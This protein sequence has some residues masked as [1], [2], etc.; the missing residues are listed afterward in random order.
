MLSPRSG[1]SEVAIVD[2]M[3][4]E[5]SFEPSKN[6]SRAENAA[7]SDN[8]Q[9]SF[10]VD[11]EIEKEARTVVSSTEDE[12][13]DSS[14]FV[15]SKEDSTREFLEEMFVEQ[16]MEEARNEVDLQSLINDLP[17]DECYDP[18]ESANF[19]ENQ[20][21][22]LG[23]SVNNGSSNTVGDDEIEEEDSVTV[24]RPTKDLCEE[25]TALETVVNDVH[26][27]IT[28]D[29]FGFMNEEKQT[30]S[31][32][33]NSSGVC[34]KNESTDEADLS[35]DQNS[36]VQSFQDEKSDVPVA[37]GS[38]GTETQGSDDVIKRLFSGEQSVL[39]F[40]DTPQKTTE[41]S[42]LSN[43]TFV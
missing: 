14:P 11:L 17:G 38:A 33:V 20:G 23:E 28:D 21:I 41:N 26:C 29:E 31:N 4:C 22:E 15:E 25:E 36:N 13:V 34:I 40:F 30:V 42:D 18:V 24:V 35:T 16:K 19:G 43:V 7:S 10:P 32:D 5:E 27:K 6:I 9:L 12:I 39:A 8:P 2:D 37:N 3:R 1:R